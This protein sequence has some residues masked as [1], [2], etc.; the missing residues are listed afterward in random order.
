MNFMPNT[1]TTAR[2]QD[3]RFLDAAI[4]Y[5][6]RNQGKT[7][8]NPSVACVL[9]SYEEHGPI[10]IGRGVTAEG[11]RPHAEPVAL[12][13]AGDA[14]K[15][16]TAYVTLE[17]CAHHGTTPPCAQTLI[18]AGVSRV[19][20]AVTDPDRRVNGLGRQM[21]E[22]AGVEVSVMQSG[23]DATRAMQGYLKA[24][25]FNRP[26][27][28]LKLA[29]TESGIIGSQN[30]GRVRI[31]GVDLGRQVHLL[32][33]RHDAILVGIGTI[34]ADDSDLRCRLPG[35][36]NRSPVRIVLD[37]SAKLTES[38]KIVKTAFNTPTWVAGSNA[39][40][41]EWR[42]MLQ[43][44]GVRFVACEISESRI[45]LPELMDDI[46]AS[47]IQSVMVEGGAS[48]ATA[49]LEKELVDELVLSIGGDPEALN[50]DEKP[51]YSP[52]SIGKIPEEFVIAE[53]L[54]FGADQYLRLV[55]ND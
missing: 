45:A 38:H 4:R 20:M 23:P 54:R 31:T 32:R 33:A 16:A 53:D 50:T 27:V 29:T 18:N 55:R 35:L 13:E 24:R 40:S 9:V 52:V 8:T 7:G 14:A 21:L 51:V 36:E 15:G 19:V 11:G 48:V 25:K 46:A 41:A 3:R 43:R 5:A 22:E 47:G 42:A 10:I 28:T 44:N 1:V 17:P 2:Q 30:R 6:R 26:F 34:L 37:A 39:A 49:F 12:E